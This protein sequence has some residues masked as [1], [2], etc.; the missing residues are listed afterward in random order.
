MIKKGFGTSPSCPSILSWR[1]NVV[2]LAFGLMNRFNYARKFTLILAIFM[3][4]LLT[5]AVGKLDSLYERY[6]DARRE[7]NGLNGLRQYLTVYFKAAQL[8]SIYPAAM[9]KG[10]V[11]AREQWQ[12]T[13]QAF[14]QIRDTFL[15]ELKASGHS[16]PQ[17]DS[18][19]FKPELER[20]TGQGIEQLYSI[21]MG[22]VLALGGAMKEVAVDSGSHAGLRP[23]G[24]SPYG[25][26]F[27]PSITTPCN[28]Q[29][30]LE[31][32]WLCHGL[33]LF[34]F[35]LQECLPQPGRR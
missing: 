8:A 31:L 18:L 30:E 5:L 28:P 9:V 2:S 34:K 6:A 27:H 3:L 23:A 24:L 11:G 4:P 21:E 1:V 10:D 20:F 15:G 26:S 25:D 16:Q 17:P 14:S 35:R 7:L 19:T 12:S 13:N 22:P 29:P 33:R 32:F